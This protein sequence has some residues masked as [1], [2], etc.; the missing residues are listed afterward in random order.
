[1]IDPSELSDDDLAKLYAEVGQT[2]GKSKRPAAME[3]WLPSLSPKQMEVFLDTTTPNM[4]LV[5]SRFCGKSYVCGHACVRAAYDHPGAVVLIVAKTIRQATMGVFDAIINEVLPEWDANLEDF[6]HSGIKT[7]TNKDQV[8]ELR[9]RYGGKSIIMVMSIADSN[10]AKRKVRGVTASLVFVEE[11]TLYEDGEFLKELSGI[12]GRRPFIPPE[13]Q[14]LIAACNPTSPESWVAKRWSVLDA[15]QRQEGYKVVQFFPVDNPSP[16]VKDYY[17][18]LKRDLAHDEVQLARDVYG[19][20][21][22]VRSGDALFGTFVKDFHVRGNVASGEL[23]RHRAGTI[24]RVGI[25][26]GDTNHGLVLYERVRTS[27][28]ELVIVLDEIV[29][30]KKQ[31]SIEMLAIELLKKLQRLG[32]DAGADVSFQMVSDNSAFNRF[33]AGTGSHDH[34][35]LEKHLKANQKKYPRVKAIPQIKE[36]PKPQGSVVTRTR[37]LQD[38]LTNHQIFFSANCSNIIE[39]VEKITAAK[40][41]P[42][43]PDTR[44]KLKHALDAL[45]YGL[46]YDEVGGSAVAANALTPQFIS[47]RP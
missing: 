37:L 4:L 9:N 19:E 35:E 29:Y 32:D 10:E 22:E 25:D 30:V 21:R 41:K 45:T 33:R 38:L 12:L 16:V 46:L 42:M 24:V 31:V 20:W 26:I 5:S 44:D 11:I 40:D 17:E 14:R 7:T 8:I 6:H 2:P 23:L 3:T 47:L 18:R 39:T 36:C 27:E 34:A 15:E 1:M 28:K 13:N 43:Q